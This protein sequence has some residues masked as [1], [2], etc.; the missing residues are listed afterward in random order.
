MRYWD[1]YPAYV[2]VAEKRAKAAKKLKK[3]QK[4]NHAIRPIVIEGS[5]IA[6]TWWGKSWNRNLER[7][8]DYENRIGRGRSYVR[9]GAVLDLQISSGEVAALV[10]GSISQ[11]YAVKINIREMAGGRWDSIKSACAGRLDSL[12]ELLSGKFPQALGEI[13]TEQGKGLF[14][15]PEEIRFFCSC[16]DWASMCKHVAA[17]LYGVG[18]RLDDDPGLFFTLRG[19][20]VHDLI[21]EAVAD[22]TRDLLRKAEKKS[23]RVL[24]EA[25]LAEVFGIDLDGP[26][27]ADLKI[28][29]P[30]PAAAPPAVPKIPTTALSEAPP[31]RGRR[32]AVPQI[33]QTSI[34]EPPP[35]KERRKMAA[36]ALKP[37]LPKSDAANRRVTVKK[38]QREHLP[39][40]IIEKIIV[41]SRKGIDTAGLV[42]RTGMDGQ[43]VRNLVHRLRQQGKIRNLSR[44]VYGAFF[45]EEANISPTPR[46]P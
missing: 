21:S 8:A 37:A 42:R 39:L 24:G 1:R 29:L 7:Y 35:G 25:N 22:K 36:T 10:Q 41:K 46:I 27:M 19:V 28:E 23:R 11:P 4:S 5:A 16:P 30:K 12:P 31:R 15:A 34:P 17:A 18:A 43:K 26:G 9:H 33:P 6:R 45:Q 2:S 44:G 32:K 13:F 14:P 20:H 40:V 38:V 3:L